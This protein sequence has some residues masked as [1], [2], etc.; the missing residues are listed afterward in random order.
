MLYLLHLSFNFLVS[1][2]N[3]GESDFDIMHVLHTVWNVSE[4]QCLE[5]ILYVTL[6]W[7]CLSLSFNLIKSS[8]CFLEFHLRESVLLSAMYYSFKVRGKDK[9]G[10]I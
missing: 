2:E 1:V 8:P 10:I 5:L 3:P 4:C 6:P 9:W 7:Y